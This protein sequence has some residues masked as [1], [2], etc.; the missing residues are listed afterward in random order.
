MNKTLESWTSYIKIMEQY[1]MPLPEAKLHAAR[2]VDQ[3]M[4]MDIG[5]ASSST[6]PATS[7]GV[8]RPSDIGLDE[9]E[10]CIGNILAE[11][12]ERDETDFRVHQVLGQEEFEYAW[13]DV[14]QMELPMKL[15]SEA[16]AEETNHLKGRT[17]QV[18]KK[19]EAWQVTGKAPTSTKWVDTDKSHGQGEMLVRS[20][21]VARD[22]RTKG[23]KD[24]EDLFC[25]TPTR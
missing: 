21:W 3:P 8:K 11:I 23:E 19:S 7:L 1:N 15:V 10:A 2:V 14:N 17:F 18:V 13:D 6:P 24:R 9:L 5:G 22:F 12:D 25:A 4:Q 20:R 16:R